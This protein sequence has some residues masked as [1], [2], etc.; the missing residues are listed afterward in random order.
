[1]AM[2]ILEAHKLVRRFYMPQRA[3]KRSDLEPVKI[4]S[5]F[6][7]QVS[8]ATTDD[9]DLY[10]TF[11]RQRGYAQEDVYIYFG[12]MKKACSELLTACIREN[13]LKFRYQRAWINARVH[14]AACKS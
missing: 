9:I 7:S 1:M 4:S 12:I 6:L 10:M 2:I 11:M 3:L 14:N 8:N 5:R 13:D